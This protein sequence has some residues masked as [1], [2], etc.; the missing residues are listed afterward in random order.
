[1]AQPQPFY[2]NGARLHAP[3]LRLGTKL[4]AAGWLGARSLRIPPRE[5]CLD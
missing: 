3:L 5:P 4:A 2:A 1:M